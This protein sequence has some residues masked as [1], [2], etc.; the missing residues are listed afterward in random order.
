MDTN[1]HNRSLRHPQTTLRWTLA[2]RKLS[3]VLCL[4]SNPHEEKE[5]GWTTV[6]YS[7]EQRLNGSAIVSPSIFCSD[8]PFWMN[9]EFPMLFTQKWEDE[10]MKGMV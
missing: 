5:K 1:Y 8:K 2:L 7:P 9:L 3:A 10:D 6:L 4:L